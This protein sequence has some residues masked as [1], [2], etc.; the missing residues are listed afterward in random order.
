MVRMP[1]TNALIRTMDNAQDEF[2]QNLTDLSATKLKKHIKRERS[3]KRYIHLQKDNLS[4][5]KDQETEEQKMGL[6]L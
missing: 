2:E 4:L 6:A 5:I 3:I 1:Y